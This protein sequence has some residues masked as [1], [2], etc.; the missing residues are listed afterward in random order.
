MT[1]KD[2]TDD[3]QKVTTAEDQRTTLYRRLLL[4]QG[5]VFRF[6]LAPFVA[7]FGSIAAQK[8]IGITKPRE[9]LVRHGHGPR[10]TPS[11]KR[12]LQAAWRVIVASLFYLAPIIGFLIWGSDQSFAEY[13]AEHLALLAMPLMPIAAAA[14]YSWKNYRRVHPPMPPRGSRRKRKPARPALP[15][16]SQHNRDINDIIANL[17]HRP[18]KV[19]YLAMIAGAIWVAGKEYPL[20]VDAITNT[21]S[22][23]QELAE[24]LQP[25]LIPVLT[26]LAVFLTLRLRTAYVISHRREE[27][28]ECYTIAHATLGYREKLPANPSGRQI[29]ETTPWLA[30]DVKKWWALYEIDRAF[31][32]APENLSVSKL[33]VWDEFSENINIKL[34]RPEEWRVQRDIKGRG[35]YIGPANYPR[36][37]LWDGECEPSPLSFYIGDDLDDGEKYT[38]DLESSP[39]AVMSGPTNTGKTSCAEIKAAQVLKKPMPWDP[40]LHGQVHVIDPKGP[41]AQRWCGRPGVIVSNGQQNSAVE[42]H[43]YN[44][45]GDIVCEKTGVMVMAEHMQ[46][47]EDEHRRRADVLARYPDAG[48]WLALPDE[49]KREE[50]FFP[51]LV[52]SDEFL[53]HTSGQKGSSIRNEMENEAREFI[54]SMTDWQLRKARNVGIYYDLIAQRANMTRIGDTMMTNMPIRVV[55]GQIDKPQLETMFGRKP[56]EIPRLPSHY[57]DPETGKAKMI[58]GRAR[59]IN[60]FGQPI[61]KIQVA[62]FGGE[63]N[64]DTLDK[65]LPRGNKPLNGDF[66]L[67]TGT[68][69]RTGDDFDSEGNY[70]GEVDAAAKRPPEDAYGGTPAGEPVADDEDATEGDPSVGSTEG[71]GQ[72]TSAKQQEEAKG[73]APKEQGIFPAAE[74]DDSCATC[75]NASSWSCPDCQTR[76]CTDHGNRT[77]NPDPD[78]SAR[79]VCGDCAAGNPY[80]AV[81]LA[82]LLPEVV[83]KARRYR[84]HHEYEVREDDDGE[85]GQLYLRSEE[86]GKKI[87]EVTARPS[88]GAPDGGVRYRARSSSGAVEGL[89]AVQDR[90]D[91]AVSTF[92]RKRQGL[93]EA[94]SQGEAS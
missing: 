59:V 25:L 40:T 31:V 77:R 24:Q 30:V 53:D 72:T 47:I 43:V 19:A 66:S 10:E 8:A 26:P 79:F 63:K 73:D 41:F 20:S 42:P 80:V 92:V 91:V 7:F 22:T 76:Y 44:E 18:L 15:R 21:I 56:A 5:K 68:R 34:P 14:S 58:P 46:H 64:S 60:A 86:G 6:V 90:I 11:V 94:E 81:G 54:V 39:H 69:V 12:F 4:T 83:T 67:P 28:E 82:T 70:I 37:I 9:R 29:A 61:A 87:V 17:D 52:I 23:P 88:D 1:K 3:D 50:K 36:K 71:S 55:T 84:I 57:R 75:D 62:W 74:V 32:W 49:V 13:I 33:D 51:I 48:S 78:A 2:T 89:D 16:T 38:L 27:I 65:W 85:Y 45:A 93:T 35:A